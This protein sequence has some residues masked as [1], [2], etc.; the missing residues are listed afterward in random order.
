MSTSNYPTFISKSGRKYSGTAAFNHLVSECGG[1]D[2]Y[3]K[4]VICEFLNELSPTI[5]TNIAK[6]ISYKQ[7]RSQFKVL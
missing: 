7:R 4:L 1:P 6:E 2:S 3:N 5:T